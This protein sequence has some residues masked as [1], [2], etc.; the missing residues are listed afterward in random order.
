VSELPPGTRAVSR[1]LDCRWSIGQR[2]GLGGAEIA[3]LLQLLFDESV[4]AGGV[5]E[6][7]RG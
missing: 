6:R 7:G 3:A 1:A 5:R 4:S 2:M